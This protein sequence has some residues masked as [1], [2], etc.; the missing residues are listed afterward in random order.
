MAVDLADEIRRRKVAETLGAGGEDDVDPDPDSE[1]QPEATS[2]E[3]NC[4]LAPSEQAGG[5]PDFGPDLPRPGTFETESRQYVGAEPQPDWG[6]SDWVS[7][8]SPELRDSLVKAQQPGPVPSPLP[9]PS[10]ESSDQ[11]S[12]AADWLSMVQPEFQAPPPRA[13]LVGLPRPLPGWQSLAQQETPP[14]LEAPR[15]ELIGQPRPLPGWLS[16]AQQEAPPGVEVGRAELIPPEQYIDPDQAYLDYMRRQEGY[17]PGQA[18]WE[19]PQ[20]PVRQPQAPVRQP[21][22][23]QPQARAQNYVLSPIDPVTGQPIPQA[24]RALPPGSAQPIQPA[25]AVA[26]NGQPPVALIIHH[27][28]GRGTA[29]NVVEGWR[30]ERPGVG[31]QYI[32]DRDGTIHVVGKE[33][34]YD[35]HGHFLHSV[36]P[37]VS[38]Q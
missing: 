4:V 34:G 10:Y 15:A 21:Q 28:S 25:I 1:E 17:R 31:T 29:A 26:P 2:P 36:V 23:P 33:F 7:M 38:N 22:A 12:A 32:M 8:A 18:P 19:Q 16:L 5:V 27:T 11:T 13:E 3:Q 30:T 35:G 9:Q 6:T 20:P 14:S 37:G 24:P